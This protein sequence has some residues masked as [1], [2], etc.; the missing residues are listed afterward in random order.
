MWEKAFLRALNYSDDSLLRVLRE[1]VSFDRFLVPTHFPSFCEMIDDDKHGSISYLLTQ[2]LSPLLKEKEEGLTLWHYACQNGNVDI[3]KSFLSYGIPVDVVASQRTGL[4]VACA[5][6]NLD[7]VKILIAAGA[8]VNYVCCDGVSC[9]GM[10]IYTACRF[11]ERIVSTGAFEIML[12]LLSMEVN[13][14]L[15]EKNSP[16]S[17]FLRGSYQH[18]IILELL[19]EKGGIPR[20]YYR[21]DDGRF[22]S[23][24]AGVPF[25]D[26][27]RETLMKLP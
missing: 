15:D 4:F 14:Q 2:G 19:L 16:V 20:E 8:N 10:T 3:V 23:A 9:L 11:N 7:V 12:L 22:K 1:F 6:W 17:I 5:Y 21:E 18:G 24:Y 26:T 13:L 25:S 27:T